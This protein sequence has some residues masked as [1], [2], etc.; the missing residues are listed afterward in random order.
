MLGEK[1]NGARNMVGDNRE[2]ALDTIAEEWDVDGTMILPEVLPNSGRVTFLAPEVFGEKMATHLDLGIIQHQVSAKTPSGNAIDD[3]AKADFIKFLFTDSTLM[4]TTERRARGSGNQGMSSDD[5]GLRLGGGHVFFTPEGDRKYIDSQ[6]AKNM[7]DDS[8]YMLLQFDARRVLR[9]LDWYA[10]E[11]DHYGSRFDKS[12]IQTIK[13]AL[14]KYGGHNSVELMLKGAVSM[15]DLFHV[16][17]PS[18]VS[19]NDLIQW[20]IDNRGGDFYGRPVEE[21][22]GAIK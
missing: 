22:F 17:L 5:D 1:N 20:F 18:G 12:G 4:S 9:R 2:A 3:A 10:N 13:D 11:T 7:Y 16:R 14:D 6:Y 21:V 8:S 19:R 15:G